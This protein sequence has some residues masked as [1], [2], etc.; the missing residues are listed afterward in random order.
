M[1]VSLLFVLHHEN[2]HF[3]LF[4]STEKYHTNYS[5]LRWLYGDAHCRSL[6]KAVKPLGAAARNIPP[7]T[8]WAPTPITRDNSANWNWQRQYLSGLG[9]HMNFE[10]VMSSIVIM[11]TH[12]SSLLFEVNVFSHPYFPNLPVKQLKYYIEG[13]LVSQKQCLLQVPYNNDYSQSKCV[14]ASKIPTAVKAT[15]LS[16]YR[17]S[18][19]FKVWLVRYITRLL[20]TYRKKIMS[21]LEFYGLHHR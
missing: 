16:N 15:R 3:Y 9:T 2:W 14:T 19:R 5:L 17:S 6:G 21:P 18:R 20:Y 7:G 8:K 10:G 4:Q 1:N 12:F 13:N 11:R